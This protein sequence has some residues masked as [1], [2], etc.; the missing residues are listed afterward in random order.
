MR[1]IIDVIRFYNEYEFLELRLRFLKKEFFEIYSNFQT[2]A[3]IATTSNSGKKIK[4]I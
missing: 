3:Y 4:L 2:E 1:R